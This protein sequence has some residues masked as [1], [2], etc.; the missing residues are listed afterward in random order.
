MNSCRSFRRRPRSYWCELV[1]TPLKPIPLQYWYTPIMSAKPLNPQDITSSQNPSLWGDLRQAAN[2]VGSSPSAPPTVRGGLGRAAV[3]VINR[4]LYWYSSQIRSFQR[5]SAQAHGIH[6]EQLAQISEMVARHDRILNPHNPPTQSILTTAI[7]PAK[8]EAANILEQIVSSFP[9]DQNALDV[10]K[11][12]WASMMPAVRPDLRAGAIPLFDDPKIHWAVA[13]FGGIQGQRILELGPLEGGH[14]YILQSF[15]AASI[16]AIES[17][18]RAF[19]KCLIV[20]NLFQ[21]DRVQFLCGDFISYLKS[22]PQFDAIIASGVLY[23]MV[24][25]AELLHLV[26]QAS[27]KLFMWTHYYDASI[28]SNLAGVSHR[29]P[30][31][32]QTEYAG[33]AHTLHRYEYLEALNVNFTGGMRPFSYWMEREEIL[34]CLRYFGFTDIR[35]NFEDR[36]HPHGP[37]FA[38]VAQR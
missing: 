37:C 18:M 20:K 31:H 7:P 14:S 13:E 25:P 30:D 36:S 12:E 34:A 32:Q 27:R 6:T 9:S 19:L 29:I 2:L 35:I 8:L 26:S 17:N 3:Q 33:F 23:N 16:L 4:L 22:A 1:R 24:N 28:I 21:L 11:N 15:G 5:L 38:F 10:F